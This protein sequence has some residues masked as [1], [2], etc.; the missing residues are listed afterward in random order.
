MKLFAIEATRWNLLLGVALLA[1]VVRL[2]YV[3]QISQAPF[4]TLRIG[5]ADAYH[6]WAL[7]IASGDWFG[8]GAFYQAPLYPYFLAVLYSVLGDG[9]ASTVNVPEM[10]FTSAGSPVL[11]SVNPVV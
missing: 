7:R 6:Q 5:D 8:E 10:R 4:F 1:L 9:A 11:R 2:V 3:W